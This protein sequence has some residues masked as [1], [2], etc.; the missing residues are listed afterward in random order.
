MKNIKK[1]ISFLVLATISI[2]SVALGEEN[3]TQTINRSKSQETIIEIPANPAKGFNYPYFLKIP[4][5]DG[6]AISN[7]M[8]VEGN[9]TG[10]C[11]DSFKVHEDRA[12]ETIQKGSVSAY[13]SKNLNAVSL[14]PVFPRNKST[15]LVY[16]HDLDRDSM[17]I[18]SGD[19]KRID[20]QLINMI[21]DAQA[22]L[23]E[24]KISVEKKVYM[25]G[26][27]ASGRFANKFTIM[28]P[29]KVQAVATGGV[30]SAAII[31]TSEINGEKLR[32]P[33]GTA[34]LKDLTGVEFNEAE[35]KNVAQYIYMGAKDNNDI[36]QFSDG[37]D[38]QDAELT[39]R[40][41]GKNMMPDRWNKLQQMYVQLGYGNSIQT[42]TYEGI[43]HE[44]NDYVINDM[45]KFLKANSG[46]EIVKIEAHK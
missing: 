42:H 32:Y 35:Y 20:L 27:S 34:D 14:M 17:L 25:V 40:L 28:H 5:N 36:T 21:N 9:N 31:P 15:G 10:R 1:I 26:Y 33:V 46:E 19:L 7:Y 18:Q 39:W 3:K 37:Y 43:G 22:M 6:Q 30:N 4:K 2:S 24:N 29:E 8:I 41:L 23:A 16:T 45:I 12:K 11:D 13:V 44:Y 38:K